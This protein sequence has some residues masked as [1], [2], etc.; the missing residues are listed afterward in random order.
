LGL[1][2]FAAPVHGISNFHQVDGNV[3]RGGQPTDSGLQYLAGMGVKVIVDLREHNQRA[4]AEERVV[5]TAGMRYVNVPMS[6][7]T[8]PTEAEITKILQLL[9]DPASGAVFVHCERGADRTGTVI[10]A[11][12]IQHDHWDN[13]KALSEAKSLG[14]SWFQFPRENY[15]RAYQPQTVEARDAGQNSATAVAA[16]RAD[17]MSSAAAPPQIE[18]R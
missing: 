8:P 18:T 14:M 7:L 2:A 15:I 5:T 12:R 1:P 9:E 16:T 3:F 10:A 13:A 17:A 4:V 11:Y 6:G